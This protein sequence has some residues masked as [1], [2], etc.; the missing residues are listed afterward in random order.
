MANI[1]ILRE[2]NS[3]EDA[4]KEAQ[5]K[6]DHRDETIRALEERSAE[7]ERGHSN[8][9]KEIKWLRAELEEERRKG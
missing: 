6:V 3:Y 8:A 4:L 1:N 9:N 5:E 7:A 2:V